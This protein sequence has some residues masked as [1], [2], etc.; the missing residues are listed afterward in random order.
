MEASRLLLVV[1]VFGLATSGCARTD[2]PIVVVAATY[3][4]ADSRTVADT[5]AAPIEQQINGVEGL[6]RLESVSSGNGSYLA[7]LLFRPQIEPQLAVTLVRNRVALADPIL[8]QDARSAGI[9]VQLGGPEENPR[10]A[11]ICLIDFE[12]QGPAEMERF[13]KAVK[14]RLAKEGAGVD[15][16]VFPGPGERKMVSRIDRVKCA[17]LGVTAAGVR[18][19]VSGAP[20]GAS[21]DALRALTVD[22]A[23]GQKFPLGAVAELEMVSVPPAVFRVNLRPAVR[24]TGVPTRGM[25]PVQAEA[26][27][28]KLAEAE[29]KAQSS[30]SYRVQSLTGE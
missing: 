25:T 9:T 22:S 4:G 1:S 15:L 26:W 16:E 18:A 13:A 10:S 2:G 29:A 5:I 21:I 11:S 27:W 17:R 6:V 7:K 23:S 19:A 14:Q 28:V 20:P 8:P 3:P 24:I 12:D 30:E